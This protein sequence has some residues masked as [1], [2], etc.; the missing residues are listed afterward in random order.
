MQNID[1]LPK[2]PRWKLLEATV[3]GDHGRVE[4]VEAWM[5]DPNDCIAEIM[6]NP[7]FQ[8]ELQYTPERLWTDEKMTERV[9][10]ERCGL[11]TSGGLNR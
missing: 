3:E 2:G 9:Y 6:G 1:S 11:Q 5:R 8:N 7:E 10:G 4:E